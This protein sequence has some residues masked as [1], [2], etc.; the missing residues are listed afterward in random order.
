MKPPV[1]AADPSPRAAPSATAV[2]SIVVADDPAALDSW[3][4]PAERAEAARRGERGR[5]GHL[6]GR[7]AAKRAVAG[8]LRA[9]GL[10]APALVDVE[11]ANDEHGRPVAVVQARTDLSVSPVEVSIAHAGRTGV[12]MAALR[13]TGDTAVGIDLEPVEERSSRFERLTLTN[14]E[15]VLPPVPG[16][17][18]STWLTRLWTAKE[19]AAKASGLGLQGRPKAF[20]VTERAGRALH[21]AGRWVDTDVIT[22][23]GS[24]HVLAVTPAAPVEVAWASS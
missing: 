13:H 2:V 4:S 23:D 3:L 14:A 18:R 5:P 24:P 6:A 8:A 15:R 20:E 19:A 10:A 9:A 17:D 16:D 21:V 12:A 22:V 11:I 1:P 7:V